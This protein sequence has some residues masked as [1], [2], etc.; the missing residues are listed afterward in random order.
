MSERSV[1]TALFRD[2]PRTP[3]TVTEELMRGLNAYYVQDKSIL[4]S[5]KSKAFSLWVLKQISCWYDRPEQSEA[6]SSTAQGVHQLLVAVCSTPSCGLLREQWE[7]P[8]GELSVTR[9][10]LASEKPGVLYSRQYATQTLSSF[11]L[12]LK[13]HK[14]PL[15][16]ELLLS[17]FKVC[18]SLVHGWFKRPD[19][20]LLSMK[21]LL[22]VIEQTEFLTAV[23]DLPLG[24]H[25]LY[26]LST[27]QLLDNSLPTCVTRKFVQSGLTSSHPLVVFTTL[28]LITSA[29]RK[30][31][32]IFESIQEEQSAVDHRDFRSIREALR[33]HLIERLPDICF[34]STLISSTRKSEGLLIEAVGRLLEVYSRCFPSEA[35]DSSPASWLRILSERVNAEHGSDS[36]RERDVVIHHALRAIS[37]T[38]GPDWYRQSASTGTTCMFIQFVKAII[39][40]GGNI[41]EAS[42]PVL[43]RAVQQSSAFSSSPSAFPA[44]ALIMSLQRVTQDAL[45]HVLAFLNQSLIHFTST[46]LRYHDEL[47]QI[48]RDR[49]SDTTEAPPSLIHLAILDQWPHLE[50][51]GPSG[52]PQR[53]LILDWIASYL[54]YSGSCGED[55]A[56]LRAIS[57]RFT[58]LITDPALRGHLTLAFEREAT[59]IPSE[60]AQAAAE[61]LSGRDPGSLHMEKAVLDQSNAMSAGVDY[62]KTARQ[63]KSSQL[64]EILGIDDMML[65][66]CCTDEERR[67]SAASELISVA[68]KLQTAEDAVSLQL[69]LLLKELIETTDTVIDGNKLPTVLAAFAAEAF[70]VL[71][72][73]LHPMYERINE[74]TNR[75]PSWDLDK[76]PI[77]HSILRGS[78]DP[79]EPY[80]RNL[81]WLCKVLVRGLSTPEVS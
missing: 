43:A 56:A 19:Q 8:P 34:F 75:G 68:G 81:D 45:E 79:D 41:T 54:A 63:M 66:L 42:K 17:I 9:R 50:S 6:S 4:P 53:R 24:V 33:T 37:L 22:S 46:S 47:A 62:H 77:L 55:R 39:M 48:L 28:R 40:A 52:A 64:Q 29:L 14:S 59:K 72:N 36:L 69:W 61:T 74:F 18:P 57:Q 49:S 70:A 3:A 1:I 51:D 11:T 12:S 21:G 30:S 25:S 10:A 67:G 58:Q 15:E 32:A 35:D 20:P 23:I 71:H 60:A 27:E 2:L 80:Y 38:D 26:E 78:G 16:A 65:Q 73:P 5:E 13:W 31:L 44:I 76:I 7:A